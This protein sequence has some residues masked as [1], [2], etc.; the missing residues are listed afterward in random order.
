LPRDKRSRHQNVQHAASDVKHEASKAA[1]DAAFEAKK[2][3]QSYAPVPLESERT[4]H[5]TPAE[6]G[7]VSEVNA[8]NAMNA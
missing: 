4:P 5:R 7:M 6:L 8:G 2:R 1:D 3:A